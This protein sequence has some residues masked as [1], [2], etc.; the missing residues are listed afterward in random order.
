MKNEGKDNSFLG[1]LIF[2]RFD[3]LTFVTT[4]GTLSLWLVVEVADGCGANMLRLGASA[5]RWCRIV[6][7]QLGSSGFRFGFGFFW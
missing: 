7:A 4:T 5:L 3:F 2:G 6:A 1:V